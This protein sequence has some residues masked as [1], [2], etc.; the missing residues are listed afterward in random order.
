[1]CLILNP[2]IRL[3]LKIKNTILNERGGAGI[4]HPLLVQLNT[5]KFVKDMNLKLHDYL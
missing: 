1:M 2:I 3:T 4:A 5:S